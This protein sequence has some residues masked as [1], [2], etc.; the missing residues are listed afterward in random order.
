MTVW[1][2]D[3]FFREEKFRSRILQRNAPQDKPF[4]LREKSIEIFKF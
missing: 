1:K 2:T 4:F 3:P